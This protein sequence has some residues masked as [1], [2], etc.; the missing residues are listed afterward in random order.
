MY[1]TEVGDFIINMISNF[2]GVDI[3]IIDR[4]NMLSSNLTV[5]SPVKHTQCKLYGEK[6]IILFKTHLH[7]DACIPMCNSPDGY[8]CQDENS[9]VSKTTVTNALHGKKNC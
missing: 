4:M 8:K 3:V 1:D 2:L 5:V 9:L 7:Y 6:C